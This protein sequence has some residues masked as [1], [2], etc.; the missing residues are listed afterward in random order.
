MFL[1]GGRALAEGLD[2][3]HDLVDWKDGSMSAMMDDGSL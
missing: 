3:G 2:D 1:F